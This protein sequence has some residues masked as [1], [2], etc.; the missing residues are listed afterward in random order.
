MSGL[1]KLEMSARAARAHLR[2]IGPEL[3]GLR[4]ASDE[5]ELTPGPANQP[6]GGGSPRNTASM[7]RSYA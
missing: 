4:R 7:I 5:D 2:D 1:R 6:G 3:R